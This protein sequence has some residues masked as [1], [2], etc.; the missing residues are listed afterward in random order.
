MRASPTRSRTPVAISEMATNS[1]SRA[2]VAV[3]AM[4]SKTSGAPRCSA[5]GPAPGLTC[6]MALTRRCSAGVTVV[7]R[8]PSFSSVL[9]PVTVPFSELLVVTSLASPA[10][11]F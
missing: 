3:P 4:I 5:R 1:Q 6:E 11:R 2:E 9:T 8:N 7:G 10:G